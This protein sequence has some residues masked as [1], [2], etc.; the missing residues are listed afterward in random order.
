ML[1]HFF[2]SRPIFAL[3]IAIVIMLA[4]SAAIMSLPVA[5]YPEVRLR[6]FG[7]NDPSDLRSPDIDICFH[8]SDGDWRDCWRARPTR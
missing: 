3:V 8:Y 2:V 6:L 1:A 7:S 5:Q 4:G